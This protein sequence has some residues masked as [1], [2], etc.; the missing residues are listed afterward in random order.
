MFL[1]VANHGELVFHHA[2][3]SQRND[4]LSVV[5]RLDHSLIGQ[6]GGNAGWR[7]QLF[8]GRNRGG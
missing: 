4:G 3:V 8:H 2:A 5:N 6:Q 7:T 1:Q